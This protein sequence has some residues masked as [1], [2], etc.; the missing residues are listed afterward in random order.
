MTGDDCLRLVQ[1]L[2]LWEALGDVGLG[3]WGLMEDQVK[4]FS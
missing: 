1:H 2:Q 4:A 3:D